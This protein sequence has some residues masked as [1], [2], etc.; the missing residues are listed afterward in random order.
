MVTDKLLEIVFNFL[1]SVLDKLPVMDISIDFSVMK[2]FLNICATVLYFFPWQKVAP[3]LAIILILQMWR[4]LL[5]IIKT[6][7]AVLPFL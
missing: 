2:T 7:W 6:I 3:I 5:S 1:E 4:I